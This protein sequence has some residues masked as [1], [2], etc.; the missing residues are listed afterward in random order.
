M[1]FSLRSTSGSSILQT[2]SGWC[3]EIP[4]GPSTQYRLA[5]LDDYSSLRRNE[6]KAKP[7]TILSLRARVSSHLIPG[8]WGFGFWNDPF[9]TMMGLGG[10]ARPL[11]ALPNAA[12]FFY[13]SRENYLS[14]RNDK[15]PNGF[16]A[17][18]FRSLRIPSLLLTPAIVFGPMLLFK[19]TAKW[20][21]SQLSRFI[22]EEST[23]LEIDV[24]EW[25]EY[26]ICWEKNS[27][28]FD[29]DGSSMLVAK[30]S[31][32]EPLGVVIWID[33][34]FAA[35]QPSGKIKAGVLEN[36]VPAWMEIDNLVIK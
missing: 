4:S 32:K 27:I 3:L 36:S 29:I 16:V 31:P 2:A 20:I 7:P 12:W 17:A 34:Q 23:H 8:T 15:Q 6:F 26:L 35:F 25:H 33:N 22:L 13:G 14:F 11:P 30:E 9:S 1:E 10:M 18:T 5:Q 19:S 21:R 28:S 24:T